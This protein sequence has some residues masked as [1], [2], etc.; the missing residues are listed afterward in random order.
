VLK[1]DQSLSALGPIQD[2]LAKLEA[3]TGVEQM[4]LN[5]SGAVAAL[6]NK[7]KNHYGK[8]YALCVANATAG[9]MAIALALDLRQSDFVTTPLTY[10]ASIASWMLL[11]NKAIFADIERPTLTLDSNSVRKCVTA[12]TKAVLS[13]DVFGNPADTDVLKKLCDEYGLWLIADAA[14]SFGAYR[15]GRPASYMADALVVSFGPAKGLF[16]GEGGA[17]MTDNTELFEKLVWWTQHSSRQARDIGL[18]LSNEFAI[19]ARINPLSA[20]WGNAVFDESLQ[21]VKRHQA[22]CL[23]I[24]QALNSTGL[25]TQIDF[26]E[27]LIQPAFFRLT[28]KWKE[29]QHSSE[30]LHELMRRELILR[31]EEQPYELLYSQPALVGQYPTQYFVPNCCVRAEEEI[32]NR[33]T[34]DLCE[35]R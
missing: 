12:N 6:E 35:N 30:L 2:Y 3:G 14:Q 24:V 13:V 10:G 22:K 7:L 19:N 8:K 31:I 15:S 34:L 27:R 28:A 29:Q 21:Q 17:I 5:G 26:D 18:H 4:H 25:T 33:F 11:G 16:A 1:S 32:T 20:I 23:T 9:L